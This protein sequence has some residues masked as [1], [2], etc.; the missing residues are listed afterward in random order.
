MD[1]VKSTTIKLKVRNC[2][3]FGNLRKQVG[4][5]GKYEY[6]IFSHYY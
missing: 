4:E 1:G 2:A 5:A 3:G 6:Y